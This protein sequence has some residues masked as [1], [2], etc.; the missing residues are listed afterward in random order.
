MGACEPTPR[1]RPGLLA[2]DPAPVLAGVKVVRP[3]GRSTLTPPAA[4]GPSQH[5]KPATKRPPPGSS[6][7][8]APLT[9]PDPMGAALGPHGV[10][11]PLAQRSNSRLLGVTV[12]PWH[13]TSRPT[14]P[15]R[16]CGTSGPRTSRQ[17]RSTT[18]RQ[19]RSTTTSK[20]SGSSRSSWR[21]GNARSPR[22]VGRTLRRFSPPCLSAGPP[23]R[24]S[25]A[26]APCAC[27]TAGWSRKARSGETR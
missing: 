16:S 23:G 13:G 26:T 19:G 14:W 15:A 9:R 22:L 20:P 7:P 12:R 10:R 25:P 8:P 18:T 5:Q 11:R 21:P 6:G 4:D 27:S 1:R 24:R 3:A 17:G 2:H